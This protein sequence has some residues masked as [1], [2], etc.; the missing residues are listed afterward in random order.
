MQMD[1]RSVEDE[2]QMDEGSVE[3]E[4]NVDERQL[5]VVEKW[6]ESGNEWWVSREVN[7]EVSEIEN[8]NE[9]KKAVK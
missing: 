8:R 1:E 9:E 6:V 2:M 7:Q 3:D 5:R 4:R